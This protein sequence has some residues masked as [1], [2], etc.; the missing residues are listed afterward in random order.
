MTRRAYLYFVLTFILGVVVG[1]AGTFMYGWYSGN[2]HRRPSRQRIVHY[3][4]HELNLTPSQTQQLQQI[5]D[6][7][8]KK[9]RQLHEQLEPQFRAIREEARNRTRQILNPQ[10]LEK[11]NEMVKR[12]DERAGRHRHAP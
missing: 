12:W 4:E 7:M 1:W 8:A 11:F 10:Q 3:L 5:I 9:D 2:W 6:D